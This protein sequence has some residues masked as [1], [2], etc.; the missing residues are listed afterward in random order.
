M[1][2]LDYRTVSADSHVIEPH[3][4]WQRLIEPRFRDRA[5]RLVRDADTDRLVC[6]QAELPPVGLLAGCA[7]GDD[8]VRWEGR[9]E[10]DVFVG[11]YD[12]KVRLDDLARDGVDAEVLYPTIGMQMYPVADADFQWALFRAYNTWLGEEFCGAYPERYKGIAMLNHED[13]DAAVKELIRAKDL[14]LAGV[15]VPL[16]AGESN[17]YHDPRFDPLWAAAVD[18]QMPVS[19]HAATTRDRSKAWNTGTATDAVTRVVQIQRVFLDMIFAGLFD[20]FPALM[21][22]SA[23]NDAGW[24]GSVLERADYWWHRN[25]KVAHRRTGAELC[26]RL[27]SEYFKQNIRLTFM[28]DHTAVLARDVIGVE[29]LMWGNDFPHHVS[30]WPRSAEVLAEHFDAEPD[31]VRRQVVCDNVRRL[32]QF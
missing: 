28:R 25:G 11:G 16:F 31:E 23:E 27:P 22:I 1:G 4:L 21:V 3:D 2:D 8:D 7:R 32:Y 5:P 26:A 30:T 13:V 14:G 24:A 6:D 15:M 19:L 18:H 10:E 17:P 20:R 29:T 12:P 9:W